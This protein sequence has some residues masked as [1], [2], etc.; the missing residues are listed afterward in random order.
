MGVAASAGELRS[1]PA[2]MTVIAKI[3]C[4]VMVEP[5]EKRRAAR[6]KADQDSE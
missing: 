4:R 5:P 2:L 6:T 3:K 1:S